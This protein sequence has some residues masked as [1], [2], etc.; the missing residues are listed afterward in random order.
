MSVFTQTLFLSKNDHGSSGRC[1]NIILNCFVM[2]LPKDGL[3]SPHI[4]K[5]KNLIPDEK[6]T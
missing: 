1:L 5:K 3:K 6:V 4:L 2:S